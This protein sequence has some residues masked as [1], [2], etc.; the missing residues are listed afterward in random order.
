MRSKRMI[1]AGVVVFAT[2]AI[3]IQ[4]AAAVSPMLMQGTQAL[5]IGGSL[6]DNGDDMVVSLSGMY[7]RFMLDYVEV[8]VMLS[9][10]FIGSDYKS[11]VGSLYGEYNVDL[12]GQ[13]VPYVGASV[14]LNWLDTPFG[15]DTAIEVSGYGGA[16]Y[17]FVDHAAIGAEL[18]VLAATEDMYN[19]GED[20]VDW[21]ARILTSWY[22]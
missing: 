19:G 21:I 16:R 17:F 4:Q 6:S 18:A 7:G 14:G 10:Y 12:G 9:G 15:S 8:G 11:L 5:R 3:G 13:V 20:A 1:M 22:F 2:V